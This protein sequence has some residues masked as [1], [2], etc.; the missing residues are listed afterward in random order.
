MSKIRSAIFKIAFVLWTAWITV[1]YC[2]LLLGSREKIEKHLEKWANGVLNLLEKI[3]GV[4]FQTDIRPIRNCCPKLI[5]CSHQSI[6]DTVI[7]HILVDPCFVMKR[8]LLWIPFYGWM[9][10]K[11]GMIAIDREKD[12]LNK[13]KKIFWKL[14][15]VKNGQL[16]EMKGFFRTAI[17][18]LKE[19][20]TV[21]LFP[22]GTRVPLGAK[23]E[24]QDG[25][26]ALYNRVSKTQ[27][28]ENCL[29]VLGALNSGKCWPKCGPIKPGLITLEFLPP[30]PLGL[31][32][33]EF[34]A[35]LETIREAQ[36][37]L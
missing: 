7:F 5:L 21:I 3:A 13:I 31:S 10:W 37:N 23:V 16:G 30:I 25:A 9:A 15:G 11:M 12:F 8:I 19:G 17:Q 24:Y 6:W 28:L 32:E 2:Y 35:R 33:E 27:G 29:I 36:K 18:R 4:T 1:P 34:K 20:R 22:E 14:R 26:W